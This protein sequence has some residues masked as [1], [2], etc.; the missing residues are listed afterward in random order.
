MARKEWSKEELK[1]LK[2]LSSFGM[3]LREIVTYFPGRSYNSVETALR[4]IR[5]KQESILDIE[6][7]VLKILE[8]SK[9]P[10]SLDTILSSLIRLGGNVVSSD[11]L[12]AI[13]GLIRKGYDIKEITRGEE[14]YF[15]LVRETEKSLLSYH[16][17]NDLSF[18]ILCSADYHIGSIH[19][20]PIA[21]KQLIRDIEE[22]SI[23]DLLIAGDLLQGRGVYRHEMMDLAEPNIGRQIDEAVH[24]LSQ[25]KTNV[26][27]VIGNHEEK[28]KGSVHVGLDC[29]RVISQRLKHVS[30]YGAIASFTI[31]K[32][33][34]LLM[35]HGSGGPSYARSYK[36]ERLWEGI[37]EK[38]NFFVIGHFHVLDVISKGRGHYVI[39]P[40]C[41]Q[42][43]NSFLIMKGLTPQIGWIIL[44]DYNGESLK[45]IIRE[46]RV[47]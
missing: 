31:N 32:E 17:L 39:Q 9:Y 2:D 46:P 30:Y 22:Y 1:L 26:H 42:R 28:I 16:P 21:M 6:S 23:K 40:G 36:A 45:F 18:P 20:S 38:P 15:V 8:G 4:R 14:S 24:W 10:V 25:F 34:T 12:S 11:V 44:E 7:E 47:P 35:S 3:P 37:Y 43:E 5:A 27:M 41:L 29:L 19:F 13:K 33:W